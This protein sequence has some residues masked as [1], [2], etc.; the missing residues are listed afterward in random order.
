M[1]SL[2]YGL[3]VVGIVMIVFAFVLVVM[4]FVAFFNKEYLRCVVAIVV[5]A[6]ILMISGLLISGII[7]IRS[8]ITIEKIPYR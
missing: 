1:K 3:K 8:T 6:P 7:T 2:K 5:L 4:G